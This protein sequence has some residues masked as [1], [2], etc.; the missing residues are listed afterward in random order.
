MAL[1]GVTGVGQ[2]LCRGKPC[3]RVYIAARTP[4]VE[5]ELPDTIEGYPVEVVETG[6]IRPLPT[7][8]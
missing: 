7:D 3:L 4:A 8:G 5:R 1:E 6:P 2:G